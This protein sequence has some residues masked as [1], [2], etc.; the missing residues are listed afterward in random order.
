MGEHTQET[1]S[2]SNDP[3][4][5]LSAVLSQ[6][7]CPPGF[8]APFPFSSDSFF[9]PLN[10]RF[11]LPQVLPKGA[12]CCSAPPL[13]ALREAEGRH[14]LASLIFNKQ[15]RGPQIDSRQRAGFLCVCL[16]VQACA[17]SLAH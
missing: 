6:S 9:L 2:S 5:A 3:K 11:T 7:S 17:H 12:I 4:I 14:L 8:F 16:H 15:F 1:L 10:S 13:Y